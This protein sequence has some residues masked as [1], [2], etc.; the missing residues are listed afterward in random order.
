LTPCGSRAI[1]IA[2]AHNIPLGYDGVVGF[3][4]S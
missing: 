4:L 3:A 2:A 1:R